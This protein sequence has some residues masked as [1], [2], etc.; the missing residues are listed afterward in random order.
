MGY[1]AEGETPRM[2]LVVI[3]DLDLGCVSFDGRA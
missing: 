3:V 1:V 2:G